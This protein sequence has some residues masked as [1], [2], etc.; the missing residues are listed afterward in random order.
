MICVDGTDGNQGMAETTNES[1][2][3]ALPQE[4]PADSSVDQILDRA[5]QLNPVDQARFVSEMVSTSISMAGSIGNPVLQRVNEEHIS[6]S[7]QIASQHDE[8]RHDLLRRDQE[9]DAASETANRRYAFTVFVVV[10]IA[11]GLLLWGLNDKPDILIP[12]LTGFLGFASGA[13]G[14]YGFGK[15][16]GVD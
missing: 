12:V 8:R 5:K 6:Q 15:S 13:L 11:L 14:G 7:L 16:T 2:Q 3:S 4:T 9:N 10:V 1:G